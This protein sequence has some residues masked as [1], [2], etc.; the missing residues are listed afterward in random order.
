M[1]RIYWDTMLFIYLIEEHPTYV[2]RLEQ[3]LARIETRGDQ[4]CSSALAPGEVLVAA[5][6]RNDQ[7]LAE[8][9]RTVICPPHVELLPFDG[10]AAENYAEIRARRGAKLADAIHLACAAAAGVD[11]FL[12]NDAELVRL[13]VRGIRFIAGLDTPVL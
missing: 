1:S 4:L 7:R 8:A 10:T 13:D 6:E 5:K 2:E 12:T 3:I 9:I 11:L